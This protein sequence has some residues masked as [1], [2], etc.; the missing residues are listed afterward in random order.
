M[1]SEVEAESAST[2][3]SFRYW[4][5]LITVVRGPYKGREFVFTTDVVSVGKAARN[6]IP[7]PDET[8]SRQHLEILHDARG[9]LLRDLGST[10]GTFLDGAEI[11]EAYLRNGSQVKVGETRFRFRAVQRRVRAE[12]F[13]EETLDGLVGSTAA[14]RRAFGLA[15]AVAP[16][17]VTVLLQGEP[18]TGRRSL[19]QV[20]HLRGA[21]QTAPFTVV[22]CVTEPPARLEKLLFHD[23]NGA[24]ARVEGGTVALLEPWEIPPGLQERVAEAIRRRRSPLSAGAM[25]PEGAGQRVVALSSRELAFEVDRGRLHEQLFAALDRVRIDLPPLR[26]RLQDLPALVS[27]QLA[28]LDDLDPAESRRAEQALSSIGSRMAWEGNLTA[29][30][31]AV[32]AFALGSEYQALALVGAESSGPLSFDPSSSFGQNKARWVEGFERRY[33]EW[34][35]EQNGGNVSRA[36]RSADMDRKHLHRLL[37]RYGQR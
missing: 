19:A 24:L 11:R 3:P 12:P 7:L 37:K 10:N 32:E 30:R 29:L 22:D 26:E 33:V 16:L 6:D 28:E 23:R 8:V 25:S 35:L 13:G 21:L 9:Y 5:M 34:L 31:Q 15:L 18:G 27:A 20:I 14:M 4:E 36:A 17:D 1:T 2:R